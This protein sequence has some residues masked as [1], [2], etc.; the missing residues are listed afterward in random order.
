MYEVEGHL[1][2]SREHQCMQRDRSSCCVS[3]ALSSAA[4]AASAAVVAAA[5]VLLYK[6]ASTVLLLLLLRCMYI[7]GYTLFALH[8]LIASL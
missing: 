1:E 2:A 8:A 4:A 7:P 3:I 5:G 6:L